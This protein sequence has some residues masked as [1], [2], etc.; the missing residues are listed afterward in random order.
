[1]TTP[2]NVGDYLYRNAPIRES[3][4]PKS[5][6]KNCTRIIMYCKG[7]VKERSDIIDGYKCIYAC[8]HYEDYRK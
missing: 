1:M 7:V 2:E 4:H 8:D 3:A 5:L 6:C